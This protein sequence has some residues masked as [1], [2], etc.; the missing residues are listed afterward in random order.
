MLPGLFRLAF[1]AYNT[2]DVIIPWVC[3]CSGVLS[4]LDFL[5]IGGATFSS[6]LVGLVFGG[7]LEWLLDLCFWSLWPCLGRFGFGAV[8]G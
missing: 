8:C 6:V 3:I 5:N 7:F 2:I 1:F 4:C